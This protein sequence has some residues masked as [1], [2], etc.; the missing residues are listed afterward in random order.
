MAIPYWISLRCV[1]TKPG[2]EIVPQSTPN[3]VLCS[4]PMSSEKLEIGYSP[5]VHERKRYSDSM[6]FQWS[7]E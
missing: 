7:N 3:F 5:L 2:P 4:V 6:T 1:E